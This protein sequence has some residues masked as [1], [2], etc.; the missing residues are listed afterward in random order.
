[1]PPFPCKYLCAA[2][3]V[4]CWTLSGC[5]PEALEAARIT[6]PDGSN[7]AVVLEGGVDATSPYNYVVCVVPVR[8]TCDKDHAVAEIYGAT[9]NAEAYG[10]D[11]RWASPGQLDVSYL[12]ANKAQVLQSIG[13]ESSAVTLSLK[14]GV[15]NAQAPP[16]SMAKGS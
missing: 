6:S 4:T 14:D 16:G 13:S 3:L 12:H 15:E 2:C 11:V 9:R 1:M 10:V 5:T 7:D 8:K